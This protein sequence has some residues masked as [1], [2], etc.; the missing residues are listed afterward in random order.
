MRLVTKGNCWKLALTLAVITG[1]GVSLRALAE[2][3]N[4]LKNATS[5]TA[6][7]TDVNETLSLRA[8]TIVEVA[9]PDRPNVAFATLVPINGELVTLDLAP[10]SVRAE[11]Y[12]VLAQRADGSFEEVDPGPIRTLR[13]TV[14]EIPGSSVA[15][16]L[17]DDGLH[18]RILLP[19]GGEFWIEPIA[20]KVRGALRGQHAVYRQEDVIETGKKCGNDTTGI[21][22]G[23]P[24]LRPQIVEGNKAPDSGLESHGSPAV[25]ELANDADVEY[26]QAHGSVTQ[27]ASDIESITNSMN[28]QY[29]RDTDITHLITTTI[30]RTVEPDPYS[31][32]NNS[33]LLNQFRDEW[34][35]NQTGVQ[36]DVAQLFTGKNI[37]GSVI[38]TAFTLGAVCNLSDAYEFVQSDFT[39]SFSCKVDLSAHELGHLWNAFHCNCPSFTMNPFIVCANQFNP[40]DSIPTIVGWRSVETCFTNDHPAPANDLCLNAAV[41]CTG[42]LSGTTDSASN[43]AT[44][45]C[46]AAAATGSSDVW[47]SYT[48]NANG[49]LTVN[50]CGTVYDTVLSIYDGCGGNEL[51]CNDDTTTCGE[52][53][54]E[55][56]RESS[57][58][59]AVSAGVTYLIRVSGWRKQAGDFTLSI[60]GPDCAGCTVASECN[61]LNECTIDDCVGGVCQNTSV[62]DGTPCADATVCNGAETCQLGVC[63]TGTPLNCDDGNLCTADSCDPATGCVFDP[64][65]CDDLDACTIDSCA[66]ATGCV[67]DPITCDDLDACTIDSCD[68]ATGCVFDP[69]VCPAGE[70]CVNGVCEPLVCNNN[71]ICESG[72]DCNNC[73][74]DCFSGSGATCGNG[75]CEAG[76]G[77]DCVSCPAD[78]NGKQDGKPSGRFCCGDGDGQNPLPCSDSVCNSGGFSCT[79]VPVAPSCC[80]DGV[81]EGSEDSLN[82][83]VDCGPPP[84]CGDLFCDPGEDQCNCSTDCGTPPATETNCTDGVDNDC[85]GFTDCADADCS[86]DPAC[87]CGA[88]KDACSSD[89]DCCSGMCKRNGTC[90]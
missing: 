45:S 16:S 31:S 62:V 8:S 86:A 71:G 80:G 30:V 67:L 88:K 24:L 79:D 90:R 32:I 84:V 52:E 64:I 61:D 49:T 51:V 68:P 2:E 47:Y 38:G 57:V 54:G 41:T 3:R 9:V 15:A 75:V 22:V 81:C 46:L 76:D 35:T 56:T 5:V 11:N 10:H 55:G 4:R 83:E 48:P 28:I 69:I 33:V 63:T 20:T 26:F 58:S 73:P 13:G 17:L 44:A 42:T 19:D 27:V 29:E 82:C 25:A 1:G 14:S 66:P 39:T 59:L 77:E 53:D 60:S 72:E 89:A 37:A 34:N 85:D 7:T 50:T 43:D 70:T 40:V 18:A 74:N 23:G 87:A 12:Q 65:T 6:L 21:R 78:C 36:R